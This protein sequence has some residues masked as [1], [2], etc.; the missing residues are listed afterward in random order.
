[1]LDQEQL[2]AQIT[3]FR[4]FV[5]QQSR[6]RL[7]RGKKNAT[8]D[9]YNSLRGDLGVSKNSFFLNFFMEEYGEFVDQGVRGKN[10]S[11]K[12]PNSPFRFGTGTGTKGGLTKGIKKWIKVKG[13]RGRDAQGRFITDKSLAFL[14]SRSIYRNGIE[15][16]LFFTKPFEQAFAKLPDELIE[17][18]A[19]DID[20][21]IE[22]TLK[23]IPKTLPHG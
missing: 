10:N 23:P 22:F 3:V 17:A 13:I 6:S 5:I 7:T 14:I 15:Q 9:L 1:M 8:R 16:S 11:H 2:E 12:A 20:D 18:F 19:L 21:F 4:D